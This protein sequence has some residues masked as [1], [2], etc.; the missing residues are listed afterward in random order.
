MKES[1]HFRVDPRLTSLLSENYRSSEHAIKELVDNAWDAEAEEVHITLPAILS[2]QPVIVSDTGAGMKPNEVQ[3]EYL[4]IASARF[5]RKG[6]R[7]P[8]KKRLVK[9][10]K[11]IGKFAGLILADTMEIQT[12]AQ[13]KCT[14]V[15]IAKADLLAAH[16]DLERVPLPFA[17]EDCEASEHGTSITLSKLNTHLSFPQPEKLKAL[18]VIEYGRETDFAI[19]VNG[20]KLV[21]EDIP[22]KQFVKEFTLPTVGSV[23]LSF[24][25]AESP[26]TGKGGG[27]VLRVGGKVIGKPHCFGLEEDELVPAKL[28]RRVVGEII[29]DG[30]A[31][32]VTADFGAI[33]ENSKAYVELATVIRD[34]LKAAISSVCQNDMNLAKA[35]WQQE[36]NRRLAT[37]PEYR[38]QFAETHLNRVMQ[39]FFG[40]G[41]TEERIGVLVSLVLDAFEKDEYWTVCRKIDESSGADVAHFAEVLGEFGICDLAFMGQ[42]AMRRLEFLDSLDKLVSDPQ[43]LEQQ[44]HQALERNLWVFGSRFGLMS[45]NQTLQRII[46]EFT[47]KHYAGDDAKDRPDL[48]L[49]A[50]ILE[51]RL[52][53]EFKRPSVTVGRG[54][55]AQAKEYR[56]V[57]TGQLGTVMNVFV[58]G[59]KVDPKMRAEY[60]TNDIRFL[61]YDILISDARQ[62]LNWLL[63]QLRQKP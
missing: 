54:A 35:R 37:F 15:R 63:G 13:G 49:A 29:A 42:Q 23:K 33:I 34:E 24:T 7:T 60:A 56:D 10:R 61:S 14:T 44:V 21:H 1:A 18:L 38:R 6:D 40:Q 8:T 45:S 41:E 22:G 50:N 53:V 43:T 31:P 51:H 4:N 62:E 30:L 59:G 3:S 32:D 16:E 46:R 57:L 20:D 27:V 19:F 55:E 5:S 28:R 25:V 12:K 58:I 11:G 47:D 9:G 52:L 17:S 39:R 48:L 26:L 36:I 2:E